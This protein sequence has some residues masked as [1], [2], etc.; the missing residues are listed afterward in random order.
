MRTANA[1]PAQ[2]SVA[3]PHAGQALIQVTRPYGRRSCAGRAAFRT[4]PSR[5]RHPPRERCCP[6]APP[7]AA[8]G[9]AIRPTGRSRSNAASAP[10]P[11]G[12]S[13]RPPSLAPNPGGSAHPARR[14]CDHGNTGL[15]RVPRGRCMDMA[16][17]PLRGGMRLRPEAVRQPM[18]AARTQIKNPRLASR[19]FWQLA[20]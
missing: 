17:L 11:A 15:M 8:G 5:Q 16:T 10:G 13:Q 14:R 6:P 2:A 12:R 7:S 19:A 18:S 4:H 1:V 3:T 20:E 9:N